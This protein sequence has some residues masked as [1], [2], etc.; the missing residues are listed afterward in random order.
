ME[1]SE[2]YGD[3]PGRVIVQTKGDPAVDYI[4]SFEDVYG[5]NPYAKVCGH[6]HYFNYDMTR[7]G[8][9]G[10]KDCKE[11]GC[12]RFPQWVKKYRTDYCGE[13]KLKED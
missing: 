8:V 6:C 2:K 5:N 11:G 3:L 7:R 10:L 9:Y 13:F 1:D 12:W 4:P